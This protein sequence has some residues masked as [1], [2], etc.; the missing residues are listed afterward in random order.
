VLT[1]GAGGSEGEAEELAIGS[2]DV[3][4]RYISET[5]SSGDEGLFTS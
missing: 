3:H 1:I 5:I 4:L 2:I